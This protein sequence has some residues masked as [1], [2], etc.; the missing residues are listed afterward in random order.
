MP[1][2]A[3]DLGAFSTAEKQALLTAIKAEVLLRLTPG[4]VRTGSSA[5]QSFGVDKWSEQALTIWLN[6]LTVEL[7]YA[8]P[9]VRV[10]P[11]FSQAV[12]PAFTAP[13][14][15][16]SDS[17]IEPDIH[18]W[19]DLADFAS[20]AMQ[21]GTVKLWVETTTGISRVTRLLPGTDATDTA[22]GIQ[23]PNDYGPGNY[24]VWYL[25]AS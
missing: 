6:A 12:L 25:A 10:R 22:N 5:G 8:Q 17:R 20:A 7:G 3:P 23:R 2:S 1:V 11:N 4:S 18:S 9:E 14:M 15:A 13:P 24:R 19:A 16:T 21:N